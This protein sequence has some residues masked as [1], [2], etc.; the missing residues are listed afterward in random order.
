MERVY[1]ALLKLLHIKYLLPLVLIKKFI[2]T[3]EMIKWG[4]GFE[5][6]DSQHFIKI[7]KRMR[8]IKNIR[9]F[10]E[11]CEEYLATKTGSVEKIMEDIRK[12][13]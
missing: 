8:N 4:V 9:G 7:T 10:Q 13:I 11:L 12:L 2:E 1:T 6:K 5:I 3:G